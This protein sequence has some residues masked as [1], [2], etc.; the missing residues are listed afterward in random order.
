MIII[1]GP[2]IGFELITTLRNHIKNGHTEPP[3]DGRRERT[4]RDSPSRDHVRAFFR[5]LYDHLAEPLA[6]GENFAEFLNIKNTKPSKFEM[7]TP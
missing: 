5:W 6:E 4:L 3:G 7:H 2:S 1:N